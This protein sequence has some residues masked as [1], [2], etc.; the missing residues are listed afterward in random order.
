MIMN[1]Q[2]VAAVQEY[3][4]TREANDIDLINIVREILI[5]SGLGNNLSAYDS[6]RF[7][8]EGLNKPSKVQRYLLN[9]FWNHQLMV[10]QSISIEERYC[11]IPDGS[12]DQW[13]SL[14]REK[15][16]PFLIANN[17]PK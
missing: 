17:L 10:S 5:Q 11:L 6:N 16:V 8:Q 1:P 3:H 7:I 9:R 12:H 13:L 14:F 4:L 15:I 2:L